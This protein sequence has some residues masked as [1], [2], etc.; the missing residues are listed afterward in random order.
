MNTPQHQHASVL[1]LSSLV[2]SLLLYSLY[3][4]SLSL[5]LPPPRETLL[6]QLLAY[7]RKLKNEF[8]THYTGSPAHQ[9]Q[10]HAQQQ[11]ALPSGKNLPQVVNNI[12]WARQLEAKVGWY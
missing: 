11:E 10:S 3:S 9:T 2:L 7:I 1:S 12:I 5:F 6:G 8:T 4:L